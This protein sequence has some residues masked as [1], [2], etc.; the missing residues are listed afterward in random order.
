MIPKS[1]AIY[2]P[3]EKV[4]SAS[5]DRLF[6]EEEGHISRK[7]GIDQ[8]FYAGKDEPADRMGYWALSEALSKANLAIEDVDCLIAA[9]GTSAQE[10]PYNAASI[11][12]H[13]ESSRRI[14]TFDV[15]MTCLSFLQA[16]DIANL[17]LETGRYSRIAVV[18]SERGSVGLPHDNLE[19]SS[20]FGDGACAFIFDK[21]CTGLNL[22][23]NLKFS[24]FETV[25]QAYDF[26][27][28][29]GGGSSLPPSA[30]GTD[31]SVEQHQQQS[32]FQM[33]G[34][35][36]YRFVFKDLKDFVERHL[37]DADLSLDDIT[38]MIP[39]QASAHGLAHM[40]KTLGMSDERFVNVF[41]EHG[42]QIAASIPLA[43]HMALADG[44]IAPGDNLL[45]IGTSAG[46]SFGASL[47][48]VSSICAPNGRNWR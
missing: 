40:Q 44:R 17:Y 1:S 9:C 42:N 20:I 2:L 8:R 22:G 15:N 29:P 46:M 33:N 35:S 6:G 38:L 37:A 3:K 30:I 12:R 26:C 10:I 5:L 28:I 4:L 36:L 23:F 13:F 14:H 18:S 25:H 47:I 43:L 39:H 16:L 7:M 45:F 48:Q 31:F 41:R 32:T 24:R 21:E 19:T 11:Y 34:R 27:Q